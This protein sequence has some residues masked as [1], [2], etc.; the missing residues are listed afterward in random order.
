MCTGHDGLSQGVEQNSPLCYQIELHLGRFN[1]N[2]ISSQ[3]WGN[4]HSQAV[5][6]LSTFFPPI[7]V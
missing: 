5:E 2:N 4:R 6:G 3:T 1:G 7:D